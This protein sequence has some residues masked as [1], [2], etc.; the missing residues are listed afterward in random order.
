MAIV[1]NEEWNGTQVLNYVQAQ[2][3][4]SD[5]TGHPLESNVVRG[6]ALPPWGPAG[7]LYVIGNCNGLYVSNGEDYS[8]VPAQQFARTTWMTVELGAAFQHGFRISARSLAP[9]QTESV[10]LVSAG[11]Y[12]VTVSATG[13]SDPG[14]VRLGFGLHGGGVDARSYVTVLNSG[15]PQDVVVTTDAPKHLLEVS[16]NGAYRLARTLPVEEP[17]RVDSA[18]G[19]APALAVT[20]ESA[21]A[22]QPTLC[23]SLL[24]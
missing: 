18:G 22:S 9:G 1:P 14:R 20:P 2:K 11:K 12:T 3:T 24:H 6:T 21:T 19:S 10:P 7:Q 13:T 15:A 8:T 17:I 23:Q 5:L 16:M 4:V